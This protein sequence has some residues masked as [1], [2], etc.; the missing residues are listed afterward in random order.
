MLN[1]LVL[2]RHLHNINVVHGL[3]RSGRLFQRAPVY[4]VEFNKNN[5]LTSGYER[6]LIRLLAKQVEW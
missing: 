1:Q 2:N 4:M 5:E 3:I 6:L